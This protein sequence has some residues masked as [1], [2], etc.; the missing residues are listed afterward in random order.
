MPKDEWI[1]VEH[2]HEP[3]IDRETFIQVQEQL[4]QRTLPVDIKSLKENLFTGRLFCGDCGKKM[5]STVSKK[6]KDGQ[7]Y[8]FY[9]CSDYKSFGNRFCSSHMIK[10][11]ELKAIVLQD[12]KAQADLILSERRKGILRN[13]KCISGSQTKAFTLQNLKE[14]LKK[15]E[16]YREKSFE[17]YVDGLISK[18]EYVK[19]KEKYDRKIRQLQKE[20]QS[21][22]GERKEET[23]KCEFEDW[24]EKF[25]DDFQVEDLT[26]EL[27]LN[28]IDSIYIYKDK[29]IEINYKF[30]LEEEP[31][32]RQAG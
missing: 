4:K 22:R 5:I 2:A 15:T 12:L 20:I 23:W 25:T 17:N 8:R 29:V 3:I 6:N 16:N 18:G 9:L 32:K 31:G 21:C 26:R 19:L 10:E 24:L 27:V 14:E 28:L 7:R 30:S 13:Y 11:E 1:R